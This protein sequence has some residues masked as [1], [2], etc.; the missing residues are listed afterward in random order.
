M[1]FER[2]NNKLKLII[3][4]AVDTRYSGGVKRLSL[5]NHTHKPIR[6]L[7][8]RFLSFAQGPSW[9]QEHRERDTTFFRG[10]NEGSISG[11]CAE[12]QLITATKDGD[13]IW[14]DSSTPIDHVAARVV[15]LTLGAGASRWWRGWLVV[16]GK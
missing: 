10:S 7:F 4:C 16:C 12:V 3:L 5:S 14:F 8:R 2:F 6:S 15:V 1:K 13:V 9:V 11:Q